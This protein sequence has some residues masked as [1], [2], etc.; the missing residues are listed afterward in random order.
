MGV[1]A[2][3]TATETRVGSDELGWPRPQQ[4][5]LAETVH[6]SRHFLPGNP[7][8]ERT[9]LPLL[10]TEVC[11]L[12]GEVRWLVQGHTVRSAGK[13]GF[14]PGS[15]AAGSPAQNGPGLGD[16]SIFCAPRSEQ[17]QADVPHP[18]LLF[19]C[20][21][22]GFRVGWEMRKRRQTGKGSEDFGAGGLGSGPHTAHCTVTKR[23][24]LPS[25]R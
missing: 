3:D 8:R 24:S 4:H 23:Q 7:R 14:E 2:G 10:Q 17:T 16:H 6:P 9:A 11:L 19:S 12:L 13:L 25:D 20:L 5:E 18:P 1:S 21:S 15:R 22:P